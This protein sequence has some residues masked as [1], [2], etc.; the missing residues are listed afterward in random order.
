MGRI[1]I[2]AGAA[3][4]GIVPAGAMAATPGPGTV[5]AAVPVPVVSAPVPQTAIPQ[6]GAT[7]GTVTQPGGWGQG[8]WQSGNAP[9]SAAFAPQPADAGYH[10]PAVG[11]SLPPA[12]LDPAYTVGDWQ[13]WGLSQPGAGQRWVRYNDDAALI[14]GNGHVA[15]VRYGMNW[16]RAA[17]TATASAIPTSTAPIVTTYQASPNTT[18]TRT[19]EVGP[20]PVVAGAVPAPGYGP[21]YYLAGGSVVSMT[22]GRIITTK[23]TTIS[24]SPAYQAG[25][26]KRSAP[27]RAVH[28]R[29]RKPSC[30]CGR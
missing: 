23:T 13:S 5:P 17:G 2:W 20:M 4:F 3:L 27:R 11:D 12:W 1:G 25:A 21:G 7:T 8:G 10:H 15:D 14:D 6:A 24:N 29:A 26:I 28:H 16:Q 9:T 30:A 19:E 18:V 22:P